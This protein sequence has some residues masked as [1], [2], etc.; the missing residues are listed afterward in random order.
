MKNLQKE[1]QAKEKRR[2]ERTRANIEGTAKQPRL[3]VFRSSKHISAQLIDDTTNKTLLAA[4]DNEIKEKGKKLEQANAV[5]KLIAKKAQEKKIE[6]VVFDRGSK[7]F[8]GRIKALA[9]G[10]REAGLKF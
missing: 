6:T 5:G 10:A 9:E 4:S 7:K 8:H 3:S 2:A 1:K